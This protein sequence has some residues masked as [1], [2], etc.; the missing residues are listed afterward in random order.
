MFFSSK[1]YTCILYSLYIVNPLV[2]MQI[3]FTGKSRF[4]KQPFGYE[5]LIWWER[6]KFLVSKE[7]RVNNTLNY[8]AQPLKC[9][10]YP[11]L[12]AKFGENVVIDVFKLSFMENETE[13]V[14]L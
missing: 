8:I 9:Q 12:Y 3:P 2:E 4:R 10:I 1:G 13:A 7:I 11:F 6:E 14:H 5:F